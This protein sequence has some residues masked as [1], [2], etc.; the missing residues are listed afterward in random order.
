MPG[1]FD[2]LAVFNT[3][4]GPYLLLSPTLRIEAVN[5]AYL[6]ATL[7]T[8]EH[9]LAQYMFDAFPDNPA[10]PEAQGVANLNASLQQVLATGQPHKMAVQHYD[11]PDI[12]TPG[13]FVVRYWEPINTPVLDAHGAVTGIIHHV[14]NIT[15]RV[16]ADVH[17]RDSQAREQQALAQAQ[18]ERATL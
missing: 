3:L 6:A 14:V 18:A 16:Q 12:A 1:S 8:R 10:T 7:T 5:D 13:A 4:P 2:L 15:D 17:L 11:V 9:L